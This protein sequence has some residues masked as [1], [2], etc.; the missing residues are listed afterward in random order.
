M[1]IIIIIFKWGELIII[2][3]FKIII[4]LGIHLLKKEFKEAAD[5]ILFA[6][7]LNYQDVLDE[8]KKTNNA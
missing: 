5:K 1:I 7:G 4:F 2:I 6:N 3:I 8:Y